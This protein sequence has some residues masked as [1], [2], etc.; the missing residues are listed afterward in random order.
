MKTVKKELKAR[1][2]SRKEMKKTMGGR[3]MRVPLHKEAEVLLVHLDGDPDRP[4][5]AGAV[6]NAEPQSPVTGGNRHR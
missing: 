6:P 4:F 2:M 3:G 5:N 1:K